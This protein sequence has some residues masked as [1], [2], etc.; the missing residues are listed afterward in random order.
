MQTF[1]QYS[2]MRSAVVVTPTTTTTLP[3]G[4]VAVDASGNTILPTGSAPS[5]IIGISE[6]FDPRTGTEA[7]VARTVLIVPFSH[8]TSKTFT[9]SV[10]GFRLIGSVWHA[11]ALYQ[12]SC[13]CDAAISGDYATDSL[14]SGDRVASAITASTPPSDAITSS[15]ASASLP[16]SAV[17]NVRGCPF[18]IFAAS[19]AAGRV[20]VSTLS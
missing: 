4:Q 15:F 3:A 13:V 5:G 14:Q 17:I 20:A 11:I 10:W 1:I 12:A 8:G 9:L 16:A 18:L 2:S 6:T 19:D 7:G